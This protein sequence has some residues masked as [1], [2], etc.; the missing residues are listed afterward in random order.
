VTIIKQIVYRG[1]QFYWWRKFEYIEEV[2]DLLQ[3]YDKL[4]TSCS[5]YILPW[6]GIELTTLV[7]I[8]V[9]CIHLRK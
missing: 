9:D 6:A 4:L 2:T 3:V 7:V 5:E 1:S 8:D